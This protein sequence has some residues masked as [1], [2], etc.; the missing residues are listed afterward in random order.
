M[1][2]TDTVQLDQ[3]RDLARQVAE[4]QPGDAGRPGA[5]AS[6]AEARARP[7]DR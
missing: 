5:G 4:A 1:P 3:A 7:E 6:D 2:A